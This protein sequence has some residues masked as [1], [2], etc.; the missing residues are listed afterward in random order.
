MWRKSRKLKAT[1]ARTL[2]EGEHKIVI[3]AGG[4]VPDGWIGTEIDQLNLLSAD[5]WET[6]F[7][8]QSIDA[9]MAEH[10]WE[11][12]TENEGRIAAGMCF[13]YLK[14][15]GNLRI[16]VPDGLHSDSAYIE[17]VKPG[18]TGAGA[19]DHKILYTYKSMQT[20]L[21]EA[22]F[23]VDRLEYFD[24]D[25]CF[26]ANP[27]DVAD[28]MIHRSIR[29]DNRNADGQPHYTSLIVDARKMAA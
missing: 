25:R 15:G 22:G 5:D 3:G 17:Y 6:F 29:F 19:D 24:D 10:V 28:G 16:A 11:H 26:R 9:L 27:W 20:M 12:L 1:V 7:S 8:P 2:S 4:V 13:R 23:K 21:Q 14:P 18:G